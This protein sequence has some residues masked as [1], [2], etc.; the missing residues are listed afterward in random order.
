MLNLSSSTGSP[1]QVSKVAVM[2][3][4]KG[5]GE[6]EAERPPY[7]S[8]ALLL[9]VVGEVAGETIVCTSPGLA[10]F[11]AAV[12]EQLPKARV[13]GFY[14]D[15]YRAQLAANHWQNKWPNLRIVCAADICETEVDLVAFPFSV[16]GDAELTRD[17]I[18]SG[19][20]AL[21]MGGRFFASI[22]NH[23][24]LWLGEQLQRLFRYVERRDFP[25]GV[26]YVGNKAGPLRKIK[27]YACEFAFRDQGRLIRAYSRPGVFSHRRIDPGARHLI[28]AMQI[29]NGMRVLD[30][31]CG[32]GVV[33]L[34]AAFR[35]K[36]AF[37]HGVDSNARAVNCTQQ[38]AALNELQNVT[39][40]LNSLGNVQDSGDY[41]LVLANPPY[42]ASFRIAQHFCEVG[43][44][45]LRRGGQILIVTKF[46]EWY[47]HNLPNWF[48]SVLAS[49][50]KGYFVFAGTR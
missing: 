45:A 14:L 4:R 13:Y 6:S 23:K 18:Q 35:S 7:P 31:G 26:V 10:Q 20:Q 17:F 5:R 37:V 1:T 48:N 21:K 25:T 28:N 46:P 27:N 43:R 38:G 33:A 15:Q 24:D 22:D 2:S 19:Y 11:A 49:E 42:Y 47:Q 29:E 40:E 34:A 50:C 9:K 3:Q 32:S 16:S 36:A 44:A 12:A 8:E 41:D 39:T 30:L